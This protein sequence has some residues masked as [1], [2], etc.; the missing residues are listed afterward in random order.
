MY[1]EKGDTI[2]EEKDEDD[3]PD[4]VNKNFEEVSYLNKG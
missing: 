2:K 3:V 4:L 1:A